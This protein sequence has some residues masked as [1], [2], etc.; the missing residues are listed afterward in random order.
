MAK[1]DDYQATPTKT[2]STRLKLFG[3][4][5]NLNDEHSKTPSDQCRKYECRYCCREFANS[6]ALGGHQNAHKKERQQLKRSQ[7]QARHHLLAHGG[8]IILPANRFTSPS[9]VLVPSTVSQL[10]VSHE[11]VLP[12]SLGVDGVLS[13]RP[14]I[15]ADRGLTDGNDGRQFDESFGLDLHLRL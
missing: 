14:D 7:I 5:V 9:W 2:P 12:A 11:C 4:N 3:F 8:R 6:Q 13:G 15:R 1:V 10:K